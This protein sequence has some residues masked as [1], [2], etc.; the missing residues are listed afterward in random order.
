[1][2]NEEFMDVLINFY[3][4]E[5]PVIEVLE[6]RIPKRMYDEFKQARA[7]LD[8]IDREIRECP[9]KDRKSDGF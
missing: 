3:E 9:G 4:E 6:Y 2:E 8:A 7:R 5:F 1:M